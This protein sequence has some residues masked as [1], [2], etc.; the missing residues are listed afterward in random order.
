MLMI[1]PY[2]FSPHF[3]TFT[4]WFHY[5]FTCLSF[6]LLFDYLLTTTIYVYRIYIS[7]NNTVK[8]KCS[9]NFLR[10]IFIQENLILFEP[11][12]KQNTSL[13]LFELKLNTKRNVYLREVTVNNQRKIVI[14][15]HSIEIFTNQAKKENG[16]QSFGVRTCRQSLEGH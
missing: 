10:I 6:I 9:V 11:F 16:G 3:C 15:H 7:Y 1:G 5:R 8:M 14:F 4:F 13:F 12:S 2:F